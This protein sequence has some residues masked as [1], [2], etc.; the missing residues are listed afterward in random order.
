MKHTF[1]R[2]TFAANKCRMQI[3]N[4]KINY[5]KCEGNAN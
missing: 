4:K 3:T 1:L 5:K 2:N